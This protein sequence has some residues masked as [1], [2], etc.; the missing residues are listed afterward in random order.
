[1]GRA[2]QLF[3]EQ[4]PRAWSRGRGAG[5]SPAAPS[6]HH[7]G[8]ARPDLT[9]NA[10]L[11]FAFSR[12]PVRIGRGWATEPTRARSPPAA[13]KS[14]PRSRTFTCDSALP[15]RLSETTT[16]SK[17]RSERSIVLHHDRGVGR[18]VLAVDLGVDGR[19]DHHHVG[20]VLDL[21]AEPG[22][23]RVVTGRLLVVDLR[24]P[25]GVALDAAEAREVLGRGGRAARV[26]P[27]HNR[28]GLAG[29]RPRVRP[30]AALQG[31]DRL[32]RAAD[33]ST[34]PRPRRERGWRRPRPSPAPSTRSS[35][36]D[37][38]VESDQRR[39]LPGRRDAGEAAALEP[40]H[41][42]A[43]LVDRDEQTHPVGRAGARAQLLDQAGR[44]L[45]T[46]L[47][48]ALQGDGADVEVADHLAAG[49]APPGRALRQRQQ[50]ADLLG[51][52][53]PSTTSAQL[54]VLEDRQEPARPR[55]RQRQAGRRGSAAGA[56][57][58]RRQRRGR[59]SPE[60]R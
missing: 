4:L 34:A 53:I 52:L 55:R 36:F 32:V 51:R 29:H 22:Q 38:S 19:G 35:A 39:L 44:V 1:M 37:R 10:S 9:R 17:P 48:V 21:R 20:A 42:A 49:R 2:Q 16:P 24:D 15:D 41:Q 23:E 31:A 47:A 18:R 13:M 7:P 43:L 12:M 46:R 40:L 28:G 11:L 57:R 26:H 58:E 14:T 60:G 8:R 45:P 25:V 3:S 54:F 27:V 6:L 59:G 33:A 5:R 30:V 50:L 56:G